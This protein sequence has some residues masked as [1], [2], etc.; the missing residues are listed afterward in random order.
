[1]ENIWLKMFTTTV[2]FYD[3][4]SK[5]FSVYVPMFPN[6]FYSVRC[7]KEILMPSISML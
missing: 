1:M 7:G 5:H 2:I 3:S 6:I 4:D